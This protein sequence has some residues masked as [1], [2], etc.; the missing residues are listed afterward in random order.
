M[1]KLLLALLCAVTSIAHATP[2]EVQVVWGFSPAATPLNYVRHAITRANESQ[3]KYHFNLV[4]KPGASGKIS[5]NYTQAQ[6][7]EGKLV[8]MYTTNIF[9]L[10]TFVFD[11]SEYTTDEFKLLLPFASVPHGL[12]T[13]S[14]QTLEQVLAKKSPT[15]GVVQLSGSTHMMAER[16][17]RVRPDIVVV[18]F[19]SPPEV[20]QAVGAGFV[21]MGFAG[22]SSAVVDHRVKTQGVIGAH[23]IKNVPP[24]HKIGFPGLEKYDINF[25]IVAPKSMSN[26]KSKELHTILKQAITNNK[27]YNESLDVD[28]SSPINIK[29]SQYNAWYKEQ[30]EIA[31][32]A[33]SQV[34]EKL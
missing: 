20:Q 26:T 22:L 23:A 16:M 13:N 32:D 10:R 34:K 17:R 2:Q 30:V 18:P 15:V 3:N 33:A 9:F 4:L 21:D 31:K 28:I 12:V 29:T 6:T 5:V 24:M 11:N 14:S 7:A 8:L 25:F 1:K 19:N 27:A